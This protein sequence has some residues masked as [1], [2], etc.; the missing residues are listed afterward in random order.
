M[1]CSGFVLQCSLYF[2]MQPRA[3]PMERSKIAL[4]IGCILQWVESLWNSDSPVMHTLV[5]FTTHFREVFGQANSELSVQDRLFSLS[6]GKT[7]VWDYSIQFRTLAVSSGWNET[8]LI[9]AFRRGLNPRIRQQIA[10]YGDTVGLE[11]IISKAVRISQYLTACEEDMALAQPL[12]ATSPAPAPEPMQIS[13]NPLT[14]VER[15]RRTPLLW[16]KWSHATN[17]S[18]ASAPSSGEYPPTEPTSQYFNPYGH[19]T[20]FSSHFHPS[21]S[22]RRLW[23]VGELQINRDIESSASETETSLSNLEHPNHPRETAGLGQGQTP[24][25]HGHTSCGMSA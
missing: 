24:L 10:I 11:T 22:S 18:C 17:L 6:Q 16:G 25:S 12:S 1:N 8:A 7:S 9:T 13:F 3:F 23:V 21:T 15:E 2:E 20:N 19:S 5:A 4:L 14:S